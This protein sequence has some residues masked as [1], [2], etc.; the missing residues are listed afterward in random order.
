LF[1]A[2]IEIV[3]Q[4]RTDA[5]MGQYINGLSAKLKV[6]LESKKDLANG[7]Q[8]RDE[9]VQKLA[10]TC[11][12]RIMPALIDAMYETKGE[13]TVFWAEE[14]FN[15]Y[16]AKDDR[17][18]SALVNAATERGMAPGMF[19]SLKIRGV[20]HAQIKKL[21]AVSLSADHP[22]A[23]PEGALAAQQYGDDSF[24]TRLIVIATDKQSTG[25]DQ[26]IYALSLNRTDES[27][28]ALKQ[29]LKDQEVPPFRGQS[30]G[31]LTSEAIRIAY[32]SRGN[33]EGRQLRPDDFGP[34][35]QRSQ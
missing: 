32:L 9:L 22:K 24:T 2:P 20:P 17:I 11:D 15:Y 6:S 7:L 1:P 16:L 26:A 8:K 3:L 13:D 14:A 4:P 10:F 33:S 29:L 5:E 30:I 19:W 35:Y 23:W 27:V 28:A 18:N 21:I 34:E 25:R 31:Q 12:S